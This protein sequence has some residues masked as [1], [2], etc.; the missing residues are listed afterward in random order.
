[1]SLLDVVFARDDCVKVVPAP[2]P[3]GGPRRWRGSRVRDSRILADAIGRR[4]FAETEWLDVLMALADLGYGLEE[5][6]A[7]DET[8]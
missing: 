6:L 1:M 3:P 5:T 2:A 4:W 7:E 8:R